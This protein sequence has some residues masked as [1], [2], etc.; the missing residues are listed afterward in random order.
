MIC[1]HPRKSAAKV[2]LLFLHG[3]DAMTAIAAITRFDALNGHSIDLAV[4]NL[5]R[6]SERDP[7]RNVKT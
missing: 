2:F 7:R 1:D 6:C 5:L 4:I 3:D